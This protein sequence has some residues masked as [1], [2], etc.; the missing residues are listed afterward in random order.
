MNTSRKRLRR[1][2]IAAGVGLL[3]AAAVTELRKTAAE[4]TGTDTVAGIVPYDF[5]PPTPARLRAAIWAPDDPRLL[6]PHAFGVGWTVN[7]GRVVALLRR[8]LTRR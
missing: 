3:A 1:T 8:L 7:V 2:G 4:R 6:K 5:R